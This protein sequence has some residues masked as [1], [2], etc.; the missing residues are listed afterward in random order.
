VPLLLFFAILKTYALAP[1]LSDENIYFYMC[2]RITEGAL[3]YRDF[4]F[5]HPPLHLLPGLLAFALLGFSLP[6]AKAIPAIF[7]ALAGLAVYRA[8]RRAG[9]LSGLVALALFLFSYDLLRASSHYTGAS[10]ATA[11]I[12]WS[13]ERALAGRVALAG[14]LAACAGLTAF[15]T[16]PAAL[17]I[18]T[19]LLLR[20]GAARSY[21]L[22]YATLFGG[23]NVL[24]LALF[25]G[26]Y[27]DPVFR[28]HFLKPAAGEGNLASVLRAVVGENAWLVWAAPAAGIAYRW[29]SDTSPPPGRP[30]AAARKPRWSRWLEGR[31]APAFAGLLICGFQLAFLAT[32]SRAYTFYILPAFPGLALAGGLAYPALLNGIARSARALAGA[33]KAR[34][35]A[36]LLLGLVALGGGEVVRFGLAGRFS[37]DPGGGMP[38]RYL[39]RDAPLPSFLNGAIRTLL[40]TDERRAGVTY[41]ALT[42]YLWHESRWFEAPPYLSGRIRAVTP[43]GS[44]LFGDSLSTPL[45]ALL[46][47]RRITRDEA[48]TNSLRYRSGITPPGRAIEMLESAPPFAV[49]ASPHRGFF[50]VPEMRRWVTSNYELA[51]TYQ[52]SIFGPFFLYLRRGYDA[53]GGSRR[54]HG[55]GPGLRGRPG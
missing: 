55:S 39:W 5:A 35:G 17:G 42:R 22:A 16:V 7:A 13:L 26:L 4:F 27:W 1:A 46:A 40:W 18:G 37:L 8:A 32:L 33:G 19:L 31:W 47:D 53:G 54:P 24:F 23:A 41:P 2:Q 45:I 36:F 34:A 51:E 30:A 28:Y 44:T 52:D 3:P 43:I 38:R 25:G 20:K 49:I 14:Y 12:A 48:D 29:F 21:L 11:L 6:V 15:Y 50:L 10:E 9:A